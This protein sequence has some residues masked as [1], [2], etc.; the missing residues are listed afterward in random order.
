MD[1]I[2]ILVLFFVIIPIAGYALFS[3]LIY[4]AMYQ[5]IPTRKLDKIIALGNIKKKHVCDLGAGFGT[6]AF[7]AAFQG[8]K[9]VTAVERDP[10]KVFFMRWYLKLNNKI[11]S[12]PLP[13]NKTKL[14]N[15]DI[16]K[17]NLLDVDLHKADVV[18]CYL[19][20][21]IMQRLGEK[22]KQEMHKGALLISVEHKI[23]GWVPEYTDE[24][25]RIYV[26]RVP[27]AFAVAV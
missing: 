26:Y 3:G 20:T 27:S 1:W 12:L 17:A 25:D 9:E 21:H 22:A 14:L 13:K 15:V 24:K 19:F 16:I 23:N 11:A 6:I 8:A 7:E 18:Y 2:L 5:R 10:F 4:G